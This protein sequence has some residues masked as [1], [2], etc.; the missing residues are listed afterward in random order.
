MTTLTER[1]SQ[2]VSIA[3][4]AFFR[5]AFGLTM[6]VETGRFFYFG[7]VSRYY[8]DP[9]F[10]FKYFGFEWV[11]LWPGDGLYWH[12]ALMRL[13]ALGIA[14]GA[15]YRLSVTLFL[16]LFSYVFLLDQTYYLNHFYFVILLNVLLCVVPAHGAWSV[17]ARRRPEL[18]RA[19]VP[20]WTRLI[21]LLQMEVMYLYAGL[22]K[23]NSDWLA[24]QPMS[25]WFATQV[26]QYGPWIA[27]PWVAAVAAYGTIALHLLGAPLLLF[28][29]TRVWVFWTYAGFHLLNH[30]QF[31]IG[32][33][34]WLTLAGTT[35]F[36]EPDWPLRLWQRWRGQAPVLAPSSSPRPTTPIHPLWVGVLAAWFAVQILFPLR[37][38]LYP[39]DPSWTEEGHR[40][41]W[42]MKLRAKSGTIDFVLRDPDSG[43]VWRADPLAIL[44]P[45]QLSKMTCRPD[46]ILQFAHHLA[47]QAQA[48]GQP[49][50]E[51]SA[52]VRCTLNGRPYQTLIDPK[53][54]LAAEPRTLAHVDWIL[55]LT[56]PL[57]RERHAAR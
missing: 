44:T 38:Y 26:D 16:V 54:D 13:A 56:T 24:L 30:L 46:M 55:P 43:R 19:Q 22:V 4:L 45:R 39:G 40:F 2:P 5:I 37:H 28:K 27:E 23:I 6:L 18:A 32:I 50:P 11:T 57:E 14:L 53:V 36:F 3:A 48:R 41:A 42:R 8:I 17:D 21:F 47:D 31:S 20:A 15:W 51:V 33:F 12:L 35:L 49:R 1:L 29:R 7:W 9:P 34:P 25:G 52:R 10:H